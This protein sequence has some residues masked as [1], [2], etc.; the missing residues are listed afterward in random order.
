MIVLKIMVGGKE[1]EELLTIA[2]RT[3]EAYLKDGFLPNFDTKSGEICRPGGA[4]VTLHEKGNLR[5]CI[6]LF[7]SPLPLYV[8]VQKMAIAAATEDPRFPPLHHTELGRIEI[9]IS[10]LSPKSL[11]RH[12]S[13]IVVGLHGICVSKGYAHGVLLPQVA[14]EQKWNR[15]EFLSHTCLKA[16]LPALAWEAGGVQIE[17]FTA[18]V[19]REVDE[20]K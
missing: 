8:T 15:E 12:F 6:G 3:L 16:G 17:T 18:D 19:F 2:R 5:G 20:I 13:E 7:D 14:V 9:E 4:F 10:V 1:K 11:I